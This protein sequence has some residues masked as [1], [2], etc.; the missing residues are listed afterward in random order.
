MGQT[1]R[2]DRVEGSSVCWA[3][4]S[5]QKQKQMKRKRR[6]F[7]VYFKE[8]LNQI[9]WICHKNIILIE[10]IWMQKL[11]PLS[12]FD[13]LSTT[14]DM[15]IRTPLFVFSVAAFS[16]ISLT[17]IICLVLKIDEILNRNRS[18][19]IEEDWKQNNWIALDF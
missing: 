8:I 15:D 10:N 19:H 12:L 7:K 2:Q 5:I 17:M 9:N 18:E 3:K 1:Q 6:D 11:T 4:H 14:M 13:L 16:S